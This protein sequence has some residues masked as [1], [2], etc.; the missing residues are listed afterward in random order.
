VTV[1]FI[2][3]FR[4]YLYPGGLVHLLLGVISMCLCMMEISK[5][6][7]LCCGFSIVYSNILSFFLCINDIESLFQH[8]KF[9][10]KYLSVNKYQ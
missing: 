4:M 6:T 10:L 3:V 2:A 8:F 7:T 9:L 1:K 5:N